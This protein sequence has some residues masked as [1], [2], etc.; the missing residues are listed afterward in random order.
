MA[1]NLD[2]QHRQEQQQGLP[3]ASVTRVER[4]RYFLGT[5]LGVGGVAEVLGMGSLGLLLAAIAGAGGAY[6]SE[7]LRGWLVDVLPAPRSTSDRGSK[8]GWWITGTAPVDLPQEEAATVAGEVP[9]ASR[10]REE[11]EAGKHPVEPHILEQSPVRFAPHSSER[12]REPNTEPHATVRL[13]E[14]RAVYTVPAPSNQQALS[15]ADNFRPDVDEVLGE[16]VLVFGV[17]GAGK[18]N[19]GAL[20]AEQFARFY[21][22]MAVF[23][24][25]GDYWSLLTELPQGRLA[26]FANT[27]EHL[28]L[29][30]VRSEQ[31]ILVTTETAA[32]VGYDLMEYG[33][34]IVF[35]LSTFADDE[36]RALLMIEVIR[37]MKAWAEAQPPEERVP[38]IIHLDEAAH[39]L[40]QDRSMTLLSTE[41][42]SRLLHTF[43]ELATT[44]RKRGLTPLLLSQRIADLHKAV[45]A[46]ATIY[47]IMKQSLDIDLDRA[48][49]IS[50]AASKEQIAAFGPG[51]AVVKLSD[52]AQFLTRFYQR[53]SQHRSHTP[54]ASDALRRYAVRE[55]EQGNQ[56]AALQQ[57]STLQQAVLPATVLPAPTTDALPVIA[58]PTG[59]FTSALSLELQRALHAYQEGY[60]SYRAL[61]AALGI[62]KDAAGRLIRQ[63]RERKLIEA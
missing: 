37:G 7:E 1:E 17:K 28:R 23:D 6:F 47:I 3:I 12:R 32:Q 55:S 16:G 51:R 25:E 11:P 24:K 48:S 10:E 45:M 2:G 27:A 22:P 5:A 61:G 9:Q 18:T 20:F 35:A 57:R 31:I 54:K 21:V 39:W 52:G 8:L 14:Q 26:V 58:A 33:Y 62:D 56:S 4:V 30:G 36:E 43:V 50:T 38:A 19:T 15:L 34:Q 42:C 60:T 29:P 53:R 13:P 44:G 59:R 49:K 63:L 40:P 46:Q 41:T